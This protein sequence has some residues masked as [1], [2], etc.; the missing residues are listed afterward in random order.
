MYV[1][2]SKPFNTAGNLDVTNS[3]GAKEVSEGEPDECHARYIRYN[4]GNKVWHV[5]LHIDL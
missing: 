1:V 2:I 5:A 4:A 3:Q